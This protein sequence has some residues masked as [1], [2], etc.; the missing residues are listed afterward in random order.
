M[1][2]HCLNIYVL[3]TPALCL[4]LESPFVTDLCFFEPD[5][6]AVFPLEPIRTF[7]HASSGASFTLWRVGTIEEGNMLVT[8]IFEPEKC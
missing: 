2:Y 5:W 3:L 8:D 1:W 7:E 6:P 4:L